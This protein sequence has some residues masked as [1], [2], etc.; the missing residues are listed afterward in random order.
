MSRKKKFTPG[1]WEVKKYA[2]LSVVDITAGSSN[3]Q[4]AENILLKDA[5]L[6]SAAP[7]LLEFAEDKCNTCC[8]KHRNNVKDEYCDTCVLGGIIAKAYGEKQP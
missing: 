1:P 7:E 5:N 2:T 6:I 3:W 4:V 8:A